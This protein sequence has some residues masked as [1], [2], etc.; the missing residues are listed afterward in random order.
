MTIGRCV[1]RS[2][3]APEVPH[4]YQVPLQLVY[5]GTSTQVYAM[6]IDWLSGSIYWTDALYNWITVARLET[7]DIFNHIVTTELDR[8][9]GI[10]VYPQNG[11]EF[12]L[13]APHRM[14]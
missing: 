6:A 12:L 4:I 14:S 1:F 10:A 9:M 8:P 5:M 11:Y 13:P 7:Y 2:Q 3:E